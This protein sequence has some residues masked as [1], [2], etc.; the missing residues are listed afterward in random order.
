MMLS[1]THLSR[2]EIL[3]ILLMNDFKTILTTL[4]QIISP[5]HKVTDKAIATALKIKPTT[6]ASYKSRDKAPYKAI[7]TYC[8]DNRLNVRKVLFD[9]AEPI[10]TYPAPTPKD[11]GKVR[12]RYF[13]TLEA[14]GSYLAH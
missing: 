10:V 12:V 11:D 1:M 8:H 5:Q 4:K 6:L 2:S 13:R 9:D 14:Y 7:L 3:K